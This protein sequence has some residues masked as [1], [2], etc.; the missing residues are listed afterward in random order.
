[1][2]ILVLFSALI[3]AAP[4][5]AADI[6]FLGE[7][8]DNPDHHAR[9]AQRV[10][11]LAPRAVVWE[12]LTPEQADRVTPELRVDP[13]ALEA[14]LGW[15]EAG[16]PDFTWYYPIFQAAPEA[17]IVGA[18][19]PREAARSAMADVAGTFGAEAAIYGLDAPL[20]EAQQADRLALQRAAHCGALPEEMLPMM[21]D[22]QRLRDAT[23]ARAALTVCNVMMDR[24]SLPSI[25][26]VSFI[27]SRA[28]DRPN[29]CSAS[30]TS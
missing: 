4:L 1:M 7:Q 13:V 15:A 27:F 26:L 17:Q 10:A 23:L 11:A 25:A 22:V 19:V 3:W 6:V 16:W 12:M 24:A 2:R 9:Q 5:W 28:A 20:P 8:H 14:A 21:V 30:N 18:A 29:G